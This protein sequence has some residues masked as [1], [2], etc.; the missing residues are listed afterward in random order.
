MLLPVF[1]V[2]VVALL[3]FVVFVVVVCVVAVIV[4]VVFVSSD[5]SYYSDDVLLGKPV[6]CKI[7]DVVVCVV[8]VIKVV[9]YIVVVIV[10]SSLSLPSGSEIQ[11]PLLPKQE[12]MQQ[13]IK[14]FQK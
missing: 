13:N 4:V 10:F 2:F 6:F 11:D 9:V 14:S 7:D 3:V 5:G 1:I 12:G 8:S